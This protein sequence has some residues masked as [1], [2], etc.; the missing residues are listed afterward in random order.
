MTGRPHLPEQT[1]LRDALYLLQGISGKY[2]RFAEK[3]GSDEEGIRIAFVD[4]P[5]DDPFVG[6]SHFTAHSLDTSTGS[7]LPK[8][9]R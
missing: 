9:K 1:L 7:F 4:D 3:G 8:R 5:V 6:T 2:V